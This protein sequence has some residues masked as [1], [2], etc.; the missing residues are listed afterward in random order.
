MEPDCS[1]VR[2]SVESELE[3]RQQ[4]SNHGQWTREYMAQDGWCGLS[5]KNW[6]ITKSSS[7]LVQLG[8]G[9]TSAAPYQRLIKRFR[10]KASLRRSMW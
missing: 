1:I 9:L 10:S 2:F 8:A 5:H 4:V 3:E 6:P 7:L